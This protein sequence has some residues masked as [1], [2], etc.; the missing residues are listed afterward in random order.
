MLAYAFGRTAVTSIREHLNATPEGRQGLAGIASVGADPY[1]LLRPYKDS[2]EGWYQHLVAKAVTTGL[3]SN[4]QEE[5]LAFR[6]SL[7]QR[8]PDTLCAGVYWTGSVSALSQIKP[9]F[10]TAPDSQ[11]LRV[12]FLGG[13]AL[14]H[15]LLRQ[16]VASEPVASDAEFAAFVRENTTHS[17]MERVSLAL[18]SG[19]SSAIRCEPAKTLFS[20][21]ER[22][23]KGAV[24]RSKYVR[25]LM[26]LGDKSS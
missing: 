15:Y 24:E 3:S 21:P 16:E 5:L 17:E 18:D 20:L 19:A 2:S 8:M 11:R 14:G 26:S 12:S 10:D 6:L 23:P 13:R 4:E 1:E 9:Y 25:Y 7:A 22:A